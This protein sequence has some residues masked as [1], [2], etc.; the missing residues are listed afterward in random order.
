MVV[1][2]ISMQWQGDCRNYLE[3]TYRDRFQYLK[4]TKHTLLNNTTERLPGLLRPAFRKLDRHS[5]SVS[6]SGSK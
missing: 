6:L 1:N 5:H 2:T 3:S 4:K